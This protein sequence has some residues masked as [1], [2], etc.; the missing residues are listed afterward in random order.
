MDAKVRQNA[1]GCKDEP[2]AGQGI[3]T[4]ECRADDGQHE[5]TAITRAGM[6]GM[7]MRFVDDVDMTRGERLQALTQAGRGIGAHAG[8][9]L[10]NGLTTTFS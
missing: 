4:G 3:E 7:Q 2:V 1:H 5:V 9:T 6:A 8:K 10:R